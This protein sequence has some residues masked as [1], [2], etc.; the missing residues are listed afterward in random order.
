MQP[1]TIFF[2][3]LKS[4]LEAFPDLSNGVSIILIIVLSSCVM[5]A[6]GATSRPSLPDQCL[7]TPASETVHG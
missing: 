4:V 5:D 3:V 7:H 6:L 1:P 2:G